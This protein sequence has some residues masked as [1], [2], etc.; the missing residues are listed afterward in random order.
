MHR[1]IGE[2]AGHTAIAAAMQYADHSS[3]ELE[4]LEAE[5]AAERKRE[6]RDD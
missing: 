2:Q 3:V 1:L 4:R 5:K 6:Q